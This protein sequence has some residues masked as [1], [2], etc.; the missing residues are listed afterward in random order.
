MKR[1][2]V[3]LLFT[4]IYISMHAQNIQLP[5]PVRTGGKPLIDALANRATNR[6]FSSKELSS[7]QISNLLWAGNGINR[8][9]GKR[10][11]PSARN[12][13][14]IDIYV[15]TAKG[16]FLYE[17]QNNILKQIKAGD[18]RKD[19]LLQNFAADVPLILVFVANYEKMESMDAEAKEFYGATD[20]GFVSQNIYLYCASENLNTVVMGRIDREKIKELAGFNGKAILGQPVGFPK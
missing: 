11:A 17:P 1:S 9:D 20:C 6:E 4:L 8:K 12:C 19:I 16:L 15:F 13:Q 3:I 18:F 5:E 7:Q 14:E 2:F 10:T